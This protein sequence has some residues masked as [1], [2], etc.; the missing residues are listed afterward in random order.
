MNYAEEIQLRHEAKM[1]E[2]ARARSKEDAARIVMDTSKIIIDSCEKL[3]GAV[4]RHPHA[5][6]WLNEFIKVVI[7]YNEAHKLGFN[8]ELERSKL[9]S[10]ELY[11]GIND[12]IQRKVSLQSIIRDITFVHESTGKNL[13]NLNNNV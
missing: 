3:K 11:R 2:N 1:L 5:Y 12:N 8:A 10:I 13:R 9:G 4:G 7:T 6:L